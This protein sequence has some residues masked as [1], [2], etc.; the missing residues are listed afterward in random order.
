MNYLKKF[1]KGTHVGV[2]L[3]FVIFLT[4]LIFLYI[5]LE[6]TFKTQKSKDFEINSI[7]GQLMQ[8]VQEEVVAIPM[9]F[10]TIDISPTHNCIKITGSHEI[11][12]EIDYDHLIIKDE[13]ENFLYYDN[14]ASSGVQGIQIEIPENFVSG[15]LTIYSSQDL[16]I[17]HKDLGGCRNNEEDEEFTIGSIGTSSVIFE[18][19]ILDIIQEYGNNKDELKERLGIPKEYDFSISFLDEDKNII[20]EAGEKNPLSDVYVEE[21]II[22]YSDTEG[23]LKIGFLII[24]IWK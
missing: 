7:K 9:I 12:S 14:L 10:T 13:E 6:P 17:Y 19:E 5:V 20:D 11:F 24:R 22:E 1:K 4:F 8:E 23:N 16:S 2:M 21:T 15:V 3:S 18:T